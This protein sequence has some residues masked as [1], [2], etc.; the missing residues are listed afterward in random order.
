M[1][2]TK[3]LT[4]PVQRRG[5]FLRIV[6]YIILATALIF[7]VDAI[8][9][10][11]VVVWVLYLIPLFLT[12][13][14][15]WKYAPVLMTGVFILLMAVSLF[16]SPSDI[17]FGYALIDRVFFALILVIA[18]FFIKDYVASVEEIAANEERYRSLVEWLPEGVVVCREG[19]IAYVNPAGRRLLDMGDET[20]EKEIAGMVEPEKR[21][22]F[23]ERL[24]QAAQGA[25]LDLDRIGLILPGGHTMTVAMS[26]G[27]V[28]WD[29]GTA[30]QIVMR[31][32]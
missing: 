11:G 26:L 14:L 8:T 16:L 29:N 28:L 24:G 20:G 32:V 31:A 1:V 21:A 15:S 22:L 9:P 7:V 6:S 30:V 2:D 5:D 23:L 4:W 27:S 12:M 19:R 17:P 25:R 18:S 3:R 10:L 13:Y